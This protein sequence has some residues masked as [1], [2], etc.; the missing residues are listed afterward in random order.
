MTIVLCSS[1]GC[2][3]L[4]ES[5]VKEETVT[6]PNTSRVDIAKQLKNSGELRL[7]VANGELRIVRSSMAGVVRIEV[8]SSGTHEQIKSLVR[9]ISSPEGDINVEVSVPSKFHPVVTLLVPAVPD[10]R[11][12]INVG[13]GS[14]NLDADAAS[15]GNIWSL[16]VGAGRAT[17]NSLKENTYSSLH[18]SIGLGRLVDRRANGRSSYAAINTTFS[19]SGH[20]AINVN[21]GAGEAIL[22]SSSGQSRANTQ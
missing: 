14:L 8:S 9:N 13:A 7:N 20:P 6:L 1:Q 22:L 11:A 2:S 15:L 4:D 16:N 3:Y 19:G 21:V 12:L 17:I 10:L 18:I 5:N